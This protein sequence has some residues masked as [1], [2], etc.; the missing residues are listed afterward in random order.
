MSAPDDP[1]PTR[2]PLARG[3]LALVLLALAA[4]HAIGL[5]QYGW[6]R[7]E[8]YY[9]SCSHR[10]AWGYVDQPP[11]SIAALALVRALAGESLVALRLAAALVALL[12]AALVALLARELGGRRYAQA[13]AALAAGLAPVALGVGHYFSMNV[14]DQCF[15][16]L[17]TL[18]ALRAVDSNRRGTWL[19][20]GL[21]LGVGLLDKWSVM[22]LGAGLAVAIVI[23]PRRRA[24][25]TPWPYLAAALA[26]AIFAPN[27][28]WE[29]AHH[30]AT[31]E[32]MRNAQ[33]RKMLALDPLRLLLGQLL[34]VG[35]GA[36]PL[37]LAGLVVALAR[38]AWRPVAI[39][40]LVT[41]AI[42]LAS[43]SARVE[44]LTLAVPALVAAGATWW[45]ARGAA[46]RTTVAAIAVLL[47]VPLVP[48]ALPSLPVP[49]FVAYQR[50]LGLA[51]QTEEHHRMGA[52]PQHYADMFGWPE[53]ADSVARVAAT[54]P[55]VERARTI[56]VVDNYGEAGA[57]ERFGAGRIPNV[58]C[59]HNN[60]YLWGPPRWDGGTAILLGRDSSE[61]AREFREVVI[62]GHA[63]HPLAMPYEQNLPILIARGFTPDFAAAWAQGKQYQ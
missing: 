61:A 14:F 8:L 23:S 49:A 15:W 5:T 39:V 7:D 34:S 3:A 63:G 33:T 28:A 21:V 18:L 50:A 30:W 40:Y 32:F 1:P 12:F 29:R 62:A 47:A 9:L 42:L 57:L 17:A 26:L 2:P 58:C 56:T 4:V 35:P 36:A 54:L 44:Y 31:L 37:W 25:L 43:R 19:A 22:W 27:L 52:L 55:P 13:L 10:L 41:L 38:A 16:V 53:L 51:P 60:W 11:F 24:L 46:A 20:L 59:Q 6:F 48:F 45:E